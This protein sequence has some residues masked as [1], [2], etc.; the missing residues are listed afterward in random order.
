MRPTSASSIYRAR[1][2]KPCT[3]PRS[4]RARKAS[5]WRWWPAND[6]PDRNARGAWLDSLAAAAAGASPAVRRDC[7][8]LDCVRRVLVAAAAP[9]AVLDAA[10]VRARGARRHAALGA[11]REGWAMALPG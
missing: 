2:W 6:Q 11:H 1:R 5:G 8:R 4:T 3:T 10:V 7:R 9:A